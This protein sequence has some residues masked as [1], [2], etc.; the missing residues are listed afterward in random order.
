MTRRRKA[1]RRNDRKLTPGP[2]AVNGALLFIIVVGIGYLCFKSDQPDAENDLR[3]TRR[4]VPD[5]PVLRIT[6]AS[7]V[8]VADIDNAEFKQWCEK[9]GLPPA[10]PISSLDPI[11]ASKCRQV[12]LNAARSPT[13]ANL[14]L[15]GQICESL[16]AHR[17]ARVFLSRAASLDSGEFRWP[18]LLGCI[19]QMTGDLAAAQ[20]WFERSSKIDAEHA[21][22]YARYGQV[23]LDD[24]KTVKARDMFRRYVS[25]SPNDG[26]GFVGLARIALADGRPDEA[27]LQ[28]NQALQK[29]PNDFQVHYQLGKTLVTL[30][31]KEQA[32]KH[33]EMAGKLPSGVQFNGRD[34]IIQE[35]NK[36]AG[37]VELLV[38]EL[39]GIRH[40]SDWPR[41]AEIIEEIVQRR[42]GDVVMAVNLADI[43]RKL[44]RIEDAHALLDRLETQYGNLPRFHTARAV[45]FI[46][47]SRADEAET[48]SRKAIAIDPNDERAYDVLARA[49]VVKRE[50]QDA[51]TAIRKS[52]ELDDGT[53]GKTVVLGEI[54]L[55]QKRLAEARECYARVLQVEPAH[56]H[57][58][59]RLQAIDRLSPDDSSPRNQ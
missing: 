18:Y 46:G 53:I 4:T 21:I 31:R 48:E 34:S 22:L 49:L 35:L 13:A 41:M 32:D 50:W 8:K 23:L 25:L 3:A 56:A 44:G 15:A 20:E 14:G 39:R 42:P 16:Q 27:L 6:T 33:F 36:L 10:P 54:L 1:S 45:L 30:G 9:V 38:S 26:M 55:G 58:R 5:P 12:F 57:A 19:A 37:S 11:I 28:L 24:G 29:T 17:S 2:A 51:E 7:G 43:Y 40:S 52:I 59:Q 47:E